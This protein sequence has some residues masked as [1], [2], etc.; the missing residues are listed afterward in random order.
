MDAQVHAAANLHLRETLAQHRGD[1]R[2]RS[3]DDIREEAAPV[4]VAKRRLNEVRQLGA[5]GNVAVAVAVEERVEQDA[6]TTAP[7]QVG[8]Q[9]FAQLVR[10]IRRGS[11]AQHARPREEHLAYAREVRSARLDERF[12]IEMPYGQVL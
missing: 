3:R 2:R 11:A 7:A 12:V 8:V 1:E 5:D 9:A 10:K 6:V 4:H